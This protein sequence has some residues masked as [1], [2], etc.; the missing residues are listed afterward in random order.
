MIPLLRALSHP[1][2]QQWQRKTSFQASGLQKSSPQ[3]AIYP[4]R[5]RMQRVILIRAIFRALPARFDCPPGFVAIL[6]AG[7]V[8]IVSGRSESRGKVLIKA[9]FSLCTSTVRRACLSHP[10]TCFFHCPPSVRAIL[11]CRQCTPPACRH[12]QSE[13]TVCWGD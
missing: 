2:N 6:A 12:G 13:K 4:L 7:S 1:K 10:K 5:V 8:G 11:R 9:Q 3:R